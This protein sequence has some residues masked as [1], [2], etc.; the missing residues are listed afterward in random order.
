MRI[1]IVRHAPAED[2][3]RFAKTGKPDSARPLTPD[4]RK[5]M[6]KAARGLKR[7]LPKLDVIAASPFT[8]AR[9]TA[10]ILAGG[11][12]RRRVVEFAE[13]KPGG[14]PEALAARLKNLGKIAALVGHEPHLSGLTA[15]FM[16][17][18]KAPLKKGGACLLEF[19][20]VPA[21]SAATLIWSLPPKVL[22]VLGQ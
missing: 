12:R 10:E 6:K 18:G 11:Y 16:G 17:G 13:L 8:R 9:Q 15:Y 5:K 19:P 22:R 7:L 3:A 14:D 2:K 1:L 4:G 20:S 21:P